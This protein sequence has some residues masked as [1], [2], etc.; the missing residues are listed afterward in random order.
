VPRVTNVNFNVS[1]GVV[2]PTRVR[3]VA[4]PAAIIEIRPEF[5]RHQYFVVRDEIVIV[6]NRRRIVA[7]IPVDTAS[8]GGGVAV[9]SSVDV[10]DLSPAEIRQVQL[11]LIER[12][13][14]VEADGVFGP[15]TREALIAF[16]R[17]EGL[18]ATGRIDSR[19]IT[20]LGVSISTNQQSTTGQRGD[21]QD[22]PAN[23]GSGGAQTNAP[24]NSPTGQGKQSGSAPSGGQSSDQSQS[25]S[26]ATT[27]QG[28][29]ATAPA[30][31]RTGGA[32]NP[33]AQPKAPNSGAS[34]SPSSGNQMPGGP[35]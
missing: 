34:G 24:Q 7:V 9:G 1:V 2:V 13:F 23:R 21:R 27:G 33:A 28:G 18:S 10:V 31:P 20:S 15:S 16:Q 29:G 14:S 5:R 22:T 17:R 30:N 8:G 3:V 26:P 6:D 35:Q 19:T 25:G 32:N 4:V 11:V 12:G